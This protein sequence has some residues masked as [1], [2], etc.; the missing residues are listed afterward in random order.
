[1]VISESLSVLTPVLC[2][3]CDGSEYDLLSSP[4]LGTIAPGLLH[5]NLNLIPLIEATKHNFDRQE[6]FQSL[7]NMP[8]H[9]LLSNNLASL[10][11]PMCIL[12]NSLFSE[13]F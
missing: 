2:F 5:P 13:C 9:D 3:A 4:A 8:T 1:M 12:T 10:L 7:L 11:V 6:C